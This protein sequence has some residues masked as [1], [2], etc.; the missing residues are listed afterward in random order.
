VLSDLAEH[1]VHLGE[2]GQ[3]LTAKLALSQYNC[4]P[5][6][7]FQPFPESCLAIRC[8]GCVP[9]GDSALEC[10]VH[11]HPPHSTRNSIACFSSS[12]EGANFLPSGPLAKVKYLKLFLDAA[13]DHGLN[14]SGLES[15]NAFL[16]SNEAGSLD[17]FDYSALPRLTRACPFDF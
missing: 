17:A 8:V 16:D 11:P 6:A 12:F 2:W 10:A 5:D 9:H 4:K 14:A 1:P 7:R 13:A 15:L 3:A